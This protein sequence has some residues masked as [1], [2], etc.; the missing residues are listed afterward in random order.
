MEIKSD[1][2]FLAE[3][4]LRFRRLDMRSGAGIALQG[5]ITQVVFAPSLRG[6]QQESSG[7]V[8]SR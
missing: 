5:L 3:I 1:T 7:K 6:M 4:G 8:G 2:L